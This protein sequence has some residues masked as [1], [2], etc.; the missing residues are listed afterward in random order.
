MILF[1]LKEVT[2]SFRRSSLAVEANTTYLLEEESCSASISQLFD[3][4]Y[5]RLL[6]LASAFATLATNNYPVDSIEIE[7]S[8]YY[9]VQQRLSAYK[10]HRRCNT[11]QVLN[12][13]QTLWVSARHAHPEVSWYLV[14]REVEFHALCTLS[15]YLIYNLRGLLYHSH[16]IVNK[17]IRY[18][19]MEQIAHRN[20]EA[21]CNF[22][23]VCSIFKL[24]SDY[25]RMHSWSK[26]LRIFKNTHCF[27]SLSH[28]T[29]VT[30]ITLG[31]TS[32][33][34]PSYR[35]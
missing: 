12:S 17:T 20:Q 10:T 5:P 16:H 29:R 30:M 4:Q 9:I 19:R 14:S 1:S 11:A 13:W 35:V 27:Q 2:I 6:H 22:P 15:Q 23:L 18:I 28:H 31:S 24:L 8:G 33:T 25:V 34:T 26:A 32:V 21:A 3:R 7:S